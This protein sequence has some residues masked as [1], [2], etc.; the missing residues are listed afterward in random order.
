MELTK[1]RLNGLKKLAAKATPGPWGA[2]KSGRVGYM[3]S[4]GYPGNVCAAENQYIAA[5]IAAASPDVVMA[6]IER[7][8]RLEKEADWLAEAMA[9]ACARHFDCRADCPLGRDDVSGCHAS[10]AGEWRKAASEAAHDG[11]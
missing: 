2:S 6:L 1:E 9:R 5:Y 8:E 11:R 4:Y 7:I 10:T 3:G